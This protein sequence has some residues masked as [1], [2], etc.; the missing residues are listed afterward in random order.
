[1]SYL[2][3]FASA[4]LAATFLPFSS[5]AVLVTLLLQAESPWGLWCAA[6]AGNTLGSGLNWVLGRYLLH[7]QQRSWFPV[8]PDKLANAQ[9]GFQK[10]GWWTLLFAWLPV[11]GD[12]LPLVAGV[13]RVHPG[14]VLL[15]CGIGK[16]ARYAVVTSLVL[17]E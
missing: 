9:R 8:K 10:Y 17:A 12:A 15:L 2:V 5:E 1:M 11:V 13:M 7:F 6:T 3:L 4:F 16:G 14:L